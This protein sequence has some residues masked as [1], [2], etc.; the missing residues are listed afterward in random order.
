MPGNAARALHELGLLN[1]IATMAAPIKTQR[2]INNRGTELSVTQLPGS[3]VV[4]PCLAL[5]REALH[6]ALRN[7]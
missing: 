6:A 7:S 4:R 5:A 2:I 1:S 3:L